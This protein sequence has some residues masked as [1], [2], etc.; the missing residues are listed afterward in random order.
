MDQNQI[1][2]SICFITILLLLLLGFLF[3]MLLWQRRRGNRFIYETEVAKAKFNEQLLTAQ[4]EIQ[5]QTLNMISMEIHD[6]VG[7][8]LSLLKVQ[9]NIIDQNIQ[10]NK[11]IMH[12]A[13]ENVGKVMMDLRDLAKSLNTNY[14][15]YCTLQEITMLELKKIS[16]TGIMQTSLTAEGEEQAL[17]SEIKLIV[18]RIIQECIQNIIKH[19]NAAY[20]K[21]AFNYLEDYLL[22]NINDDG[23]GFD[24]EI[25]TS[26]GAGLGIKNL[27]S[28]AAL[29]GGEA[30]IKSIINEGTTVNIITPYA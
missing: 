13:R 28:R 3:F 17:R 25:L 30:T 2:F 8:T 21:I 10:V 5:E 1:I 9:L 4:L 26:G 16:N 22:I 14:I 29:I 27:I 15:Q 12:E 7:Q 11:T 18:F 23:K 6:N 19:S 20:L 24:E